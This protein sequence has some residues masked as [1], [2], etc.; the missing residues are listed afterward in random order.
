MIPPREAFVKGEWR[1]EPCATCKR[2]VMQNVATEHLCIDCKLVALET[3][4]FRLRAALEH[5]ANDGGTQRLY[6][7][8][9]P[10]F[11]RNVIEGIK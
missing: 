7:A 8:D 3:E 11:A 9:V 4:A 5:I 2:E 6:L 1:E 10:Q